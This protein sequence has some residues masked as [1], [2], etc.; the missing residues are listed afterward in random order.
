MVQE[1][2]V[3]QRV[4]TTTPS[5]A[6]Y[7]AP[8][9]AP[10]GAP[11]A[12]DAVTTRT[13]TRSPSA[14]EMLRRIVVFVFALIQAVIL[15]RLVLLLINA[16]RNNGIVEFIYTTSSWFVAPFEGIVRTDAL[17]RGASVL[18][19]TAIVALIGWT[20]VELIIVAGINIARRE[21]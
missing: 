10:Y 5:V 9:A 19:V 3:T 18:D 14:A 11:V 1:E 6:P 8:V 21:P 20:I 17:Q 12:A 7:G 15:L 2:Q 16:S 4:V 13:V